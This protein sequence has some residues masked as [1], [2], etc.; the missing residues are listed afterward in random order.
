MNAPRGKPNFSSP[1][2]APP[3]P[4]AEPR[5]GRWF[6]GRWHTYA[7]SATF[8]A[9][10]DAPDSRDGRWAEP[11]GIHQHNVRQ[12]G[13]LRLSNFRFIRRKSPANEWLAGKATWHWK[14]SKK[15]A[16]CAIDCATARTAQAGTPTELRC[17]LVGARPD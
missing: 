5:H 6:L 3:R 2:G 9:R 11:G 4:V 7:A 1:R 10:S 12:I 17:L 16:F 13:G 15:L 14:P 8:R